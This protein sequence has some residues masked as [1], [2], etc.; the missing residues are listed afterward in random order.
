MFYRRHFGPFGFGFGCRPFGFFFHGFW[1]YPNRSEYLKWLEEYK[2]DLEE[3]LK[4]VE[5]EIEKLKKE[6]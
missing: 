6:I 2:K 3:E 1:T 5:K 4:A